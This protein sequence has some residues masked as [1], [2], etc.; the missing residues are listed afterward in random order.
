MTTDDDERRL[1]INMGF[2]KVANSIGV[3]GGRVGNMGP[4]GTTPNMWPESPP[5][6][7]DWA[8]CSP[9]P[10]A[11]CGAAGPIPLPNGASGA[12]ADV[13]PSPS[14]ERQ[15][16]GEV[17]PTPVLD[18]GLVRPPDRGGEQ[19]VRGRPIARESSPSWI[20]GCMGQNGARMWH[21][22]A[23]MGHGRGTDGPHWDA[24]GA[25][26]GRNG[27]RNNG[28]WMW[29]GWATLRHGWGTDEP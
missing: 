18:F 12:N 21:R 27:A 13:R 14:R 3:A 15:T 9:T 20:V 6:I 10:S 22:C 23:A 24:N 19:A 11:P 17:Y 5:Q 28:M 29:H 26:M 7:L 4:E 16:P 2:A 25:R 8:K 1:S